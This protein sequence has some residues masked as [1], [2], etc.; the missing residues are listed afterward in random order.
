MAGRRREE[1]IVSTGA[2]WPS[3]LIHG[4]W[5]DGIR[6]P[7]ETAPGIGI[8]PRLAGIAR[9]LAPRAVRRHRR[10][11]PVTQRMNFNLEP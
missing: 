3:T 8:H 6:I 1:P 11:E 7:A 9:L 5:S 10:V 4:R 2:R